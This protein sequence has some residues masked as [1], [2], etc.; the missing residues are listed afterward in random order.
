MNNKEVI[1]SFLACDDLSEIETL[2]KNKA[3][4]LDASLA[5]A[6]ED[7]YKAEL[8]LS[9]KRN[10]VIQLTHQLEGTISLI[11]DVIACNSKKEQL[12]EIK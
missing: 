10:K 11:L 1:D 2:I 6:K 3:L 4:V 8:D 12:E 7:F 9:N 5:E